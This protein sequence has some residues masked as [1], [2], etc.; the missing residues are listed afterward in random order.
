M[1]ARVAQIGLAAELVGVIALG[2]YLLIFQRENSFSVFFDSHGRRRSDA[3]LFTFF[4]AV[5]S[6]FFLFYGFEA[7]GSV[8][9]EVDDPTRRIPKAMIL[10]ILI[11]GVSGLFSYIGYVLAAPNLQAIVDGEIPDPIPSILEDSLGTAGSKV[12]LVIAI[13][14]FVSC[15]LSLQAAG[16]RL[17]YSSARD[18]MLPMSPWLAHMSPRHAV[19]TNALLVA[20]V[21]P[22]LICVYVYAIP[23]Q[24]PRVTAFA[25]LG[26]YIAFQAVVL[27]A[28]RQRLKG[29]D[30]PVTG[31]WV[32]R[33]GGQRPRAGLRHHGH[34]L[35]CS[36]RGTP[37]AGWTTRSCD[38][39]EG[40][41]RHRAALPVDREAGS[42]L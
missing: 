21:V 13:T 2:L 31:T 25:V 14:A 38:R 41:A 11:G 29:G 16:S 20:C 32:G 35:A 19:P 18:R 4:G 23:D 27:A 26:I 1:L 15:V 7:C 39:P 24:L 5:L 42:P 8:A 12:F 40:R 37:A 10:T 33:D 17:F 36:S 30:R 34:L 22:I 28:L 3:Y 9:E 6:G